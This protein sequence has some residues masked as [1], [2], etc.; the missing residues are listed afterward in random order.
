MERQVQQEFDKE[1]DKY[2][3]IEEALRGG[4]GDLE[5]DGDCGG[6]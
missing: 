3:Q 2:G 6:A 4:G 1:Y 5:V